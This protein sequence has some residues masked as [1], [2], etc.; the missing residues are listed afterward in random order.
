MGPQGRF[1]DWRFSILETKL[2]MRQMLKDKNVYS[3]VKD[4]LKGNMYVVCYHQTYM[5]GTPFHL[6]VDLFCFKRLC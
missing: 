4:N 5:C 2:S 3:T 6:I 1:E